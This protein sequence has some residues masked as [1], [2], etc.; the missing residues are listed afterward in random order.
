[1]AQQFIND[2]GAP[3]GSG[4][5][6]SAK[7]KSVPKA[8]AKAAA[9]FPSVGLTLRS[10]NYDALSSNQHLPQKAGTV[11]KRGW[12]RRIPWKRILITLLVI[13]LLAGAWVGAKFLYN[14]HKVFGGSIFGL[15]HT[16]HLKGEDTGRVNIL[17]AGNSADDPGHDGGN[18]T[19]SIMLVSIDTKNNSGFMLSIPRDLWVTIP[20]YGS[21]KINAAY[22]AGQ[23]ND[24]N[25]NGYPSGGMGQLEQIIEQDFGINIDYYALVNYAALKQAVDAVGGIKVNIQSSDPRGLYDPSIDYVTHG[26]LV[27]LSNG[28]HTLDGEQALDLARARGDDYRAYGFA[29]SDFERT[30]NQRLMLVALKNKIF[31]TGVLANPTKLGSLADAIGNNV[32]TDFQTSEVH[33]LY[34]LVKNVPSNRIQSLSLN[35][36]NGKNLLMSYAAPDGESALAPAAGLDNYDDIQAFINQQTSD[37]PLVRENASIVV[38][39][40]T[41]TNG[42]ASHEKFVLQRKNLYVAVVA[43]ADKLQANTTIIDASGGSLPATRGILKRIFGDHFT[44]TN[45]YKYGYPSADFIILVGRDQVQKSTSNNTAN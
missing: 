5:K 21:Q 38:L 41:D 24:F 8:Q 2:F 11:V 42:L 29:G 18:L 4:L 36:A 20:G 27:K 30:Q 32:K 33:R 13:I 35:D 39:N 12:W 44:T 26:P 37:D 3:R 22:V 17:L 1:M 34:D 7:I 14:T 25:E 45:P 28:E 15:L 40:A 19:D 16:T 43:D 6:P 31:S 10:Y 9:A 23:A